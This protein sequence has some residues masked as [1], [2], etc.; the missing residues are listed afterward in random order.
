MNVIVLGGTQ[1]V[2]WHIVEALRARGHRVTTLTRG[3]TP[4]E[5][6]DSVE[7]L[8]GD[9]DAGPAGLA[10]LS[11]R[12]W[13]ACIDVSGYTPRQVR[14]S[15][16][17]L[18]SRV[19]RYVFISAVSVYGDP[20]DRPVTEAH[21]RVSPAAEGAT[22]VVGEMYG[23]LKVACEDIVQQLYGDGCTLFRP[24]IVAGPHDPLDRY[25]YWVRR[26]GQGGEMLA[27]GDG[28]DHVQV[29]DARDVGRFSATAIE[30]GLGGAFNLAG[31]RLPW[32]NFLRVL[33]AEDPV[34][35]PADVVRAQG[36]TEFELPLFRPERG[37]RSG[38]MD[39]SAERA[40]A[41][42]LEL[43]PPHV[44]AR[45]TRAWLVEREQAAQDGR[46]RAARLDPALA[47][48]REAELI[49]IA[50]GGA[51]PGPRA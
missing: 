28:R 48:E 26:A 46:S 33:G 1:F 27:P 25:S 7:R 41:A 51:A 10:A 14:P 17:A 39:V 13:D 20:I 21:P 3:R 49:R 9:R 8:R 23:R 36:V 5:P 45:D 11:G 6:A 30:R 24:Q 32:A 50:R 35:V 16:E 42:G 43:T 31:P 2:G 38:L 18:R 12:S 19:A 22:E 47:P 34:W 15:A 44:T 40:L 37:P 4:D 29:I